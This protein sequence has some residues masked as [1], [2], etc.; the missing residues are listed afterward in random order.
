MVSLV[1]INLLLKDISDLIH[2]DLTKFSC[3]YFLL[4]LLLSKYSSRGVQN[5]IEFQFQ[6]CC[7]LLFDFGNRERNEIL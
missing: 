6:L 3:F 2:F 1:M 4:L 7:S 5:E